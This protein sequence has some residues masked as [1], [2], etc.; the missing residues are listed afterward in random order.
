M[1]IY[2]NKAV[3]IRARLAAPDTA[4]AEVC[5]MQQEALRVAHCRMDTAKEGVSLHLA[6]YVYESRYNYS[7]SIN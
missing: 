7:C 5:L 2:M 6:C 4:A 1:R 3:Y